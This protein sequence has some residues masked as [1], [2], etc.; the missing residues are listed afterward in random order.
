MNRFMKMNERQRESII[1]GIKEVMGN[2]LPD[3]LMDEISGGRLLNN[4]EYFD[5]LSKGYDYTQQYNQGK[6]SE[7]EYNSLLKAF[8]NYIDYIDSLDEGS[9]TVLF[10]F[11]RF[12]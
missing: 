7:E 3:E 12:K 4:K 10:D 1:N 6:M 2:E 11:E 8:D 9:E 5:F